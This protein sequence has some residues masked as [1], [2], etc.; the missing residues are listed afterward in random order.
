LRN[1]VKVTPGALRSITV[2]RSGGVAMFNLDRWREILDTLWR[3]K[4][5]SLLT[6]FSVALLGSAGSP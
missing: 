5:R 6:A 1:L 2:A 3:S 4:L